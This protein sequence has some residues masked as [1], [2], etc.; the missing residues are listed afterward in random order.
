MKSPSV[1]L[2]RRERV[3]SREGHSARFAEEWLQ[4]RRSRGRARRWPGAAALAHI[5]PS[6]FC[7]L[8][9]AGVALDQSRPDPLFELSYLSA[10]CLL[11]EVNL[12]PC[13][14][15]VELLGDG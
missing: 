15:E 12:F 1:L 10:E 3:I 14:G 11:G 8:D 6:C 9:V 7:Q 4:L 2:A 13:A 5:G